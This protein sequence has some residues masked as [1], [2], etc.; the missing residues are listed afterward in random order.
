MLGL[1]RC[2]EILAV[3][4]LFST[5]LRDSMFPDGITTPEVLIVLLLLVI[6]D[7]VIRIKSRI[8]L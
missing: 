7:D 4:S 2:A 8:E 1:L 6:W 3:V 5:D